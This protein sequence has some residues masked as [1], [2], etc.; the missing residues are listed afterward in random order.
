[1]TTHITKPILTK[2]LSGGLAQQPPKT[3]TTTSAKKSDFDSGLQEKLNDPNQ[4]VAQ[5]LTLLNSL[6][7]QIS[8]FDMSSIKKIITAPTFLMDLSKEFNKQF[9]KF[10][11]KQKKEF[12]KVINESVELVELDVNKSAIRGSEAATN[13][14]QNSLLAAISVIPGGGALFNIIYTSLRNLWNGFSWTAQAIA[15]LKISINKML[16][17]P[18]VDLVLKMPIVFLEKTLEQLKMGCSAS[19]KGCPM[20]VSTKV[21]GARKKRDFYSRINKIS[22]RTNKSIKQFLKKRNCKTR[23]H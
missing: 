2:T 8:K 18:N 17:M 23:R 6:S 9:S 20:N 4:V 14:A 21:G 3:A 22:R 7:S 19:R 5:Q 16:K 13:I 11:D 12:Y 1:M 10:N 15:D